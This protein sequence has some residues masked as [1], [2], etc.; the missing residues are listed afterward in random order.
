MKVIVKPK[1]IIKFFDIMIHNKNSNG[2]TGVK[3]NTFIIS[4]NDY[5]LVKD[6]VILI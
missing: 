1:N 3:N 5:K 4:D 6:L 2:F